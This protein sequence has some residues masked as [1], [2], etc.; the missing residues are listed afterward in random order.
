METTT[1][2][3]NQ[4]VCRIVEPRPSGSIYKILFNLWLK[5]QYKRRGRKILVTEGSRNFI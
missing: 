2:K 4:S 1:D 3:H 5:E